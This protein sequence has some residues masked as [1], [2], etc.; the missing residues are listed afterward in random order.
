VDPV[1]LVTICDRTSLLDFLLARVQIS[2]SASVPTADDSHSRSRFSSE[3]LLSEID[4]NQAYATELLNLMLTVEPP[5][6]TAAQKSRR[7]E[8]VCVCVCVYKV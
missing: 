6:E 5:A 2:L 3:K 1:I 8:G 7:E 4:E